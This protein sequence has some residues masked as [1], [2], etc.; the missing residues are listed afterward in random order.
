MHLDCTK[1]IHSPLSIYIVLTLPMLIDRLNKK[2]SITTFDR[3]IIWGNYHFSLASVTNRLFNIINGINDPA[4][5]AERD[6]DHDVMQLS[7]RYR[8]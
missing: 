4:S 6:D 1:K 3:H 7:G 8:G 5:L 2:Y